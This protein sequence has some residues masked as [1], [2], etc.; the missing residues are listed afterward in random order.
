MGLQF[1]RK[2]TK[3]FYFKTT[4]AVP[5]SEIEF[6]NGKFEVVNK[7]ENFPVVFV[8]FNGANKYAISNGDRLPTEA[9]WEFAA[10]WNGKKKIS[11]WNF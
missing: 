5:F 6:T 9:E 1:V 3:Q 7:R 8:T 4:D 2:I 11:L 10:S